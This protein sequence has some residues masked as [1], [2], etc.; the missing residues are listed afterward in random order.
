METAQ[1]GVL[2][3]Q[4]VIVFCYDRE[5]DEVFDPFADGVAKFD[6]WLLLWFQTNYWGLLDVAR[7][8]WARIY[9]ELRAGVA[10]EASKEE[11][12]A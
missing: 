8:Q 11:A 5:A 10:R 1:E 2:S 12:L 3:S 4:K 7:K 9:D 6:L